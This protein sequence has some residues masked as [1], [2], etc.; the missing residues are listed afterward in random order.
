MISLKYPTYK[1]G[2]QLTLH[3]QVDFRSDHCN[4][5]GNLQNEIKRNLIRRK[6]MYGSPFFLQMM[7]TIKP[8]IAR[9]VTKDVTIAATTSAKDG[10]CPLGSLPVIY[11]NNIC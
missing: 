2:H 3:N 9:S 6:K 7:N 8:I 5:Y 10:P 4:G 11:R 1:K